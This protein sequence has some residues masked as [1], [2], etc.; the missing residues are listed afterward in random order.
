MRVEDIFEDMTRG[1]RKFNDFLKEI[2]PWEDYISRDWQNEFRKKQAELAGAELKT[3]RQLS[4]LLQDIRGGQDK[5]SEMEKLLDNFDRENPCSSMSIEQFL[6]KKR[7]V[8]SKIEILKKFERKQNLLKEITSIEDMVSKYYQQD[9]YL[10][11]I[12]ENWQTKDKENSLTQLR[13]FQY[14]INSEKSINDGEPNDTT[15]NSAFIVI[16]YDLHRSDLEDDENKANKCCIYHATRGKIKSKDFYE[17]SLSKFMK[18]LDSPEV[19]TKFVN[20]F[21]LHSNIF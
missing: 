21:R 10:L 11:H 13:Y 9:L 19:E 17:D 4:I 1:K 2:K 18:Q 15:S 6:R 5:E 8:K 16:D 14:L 3:Q 12:S 7:N 20:E